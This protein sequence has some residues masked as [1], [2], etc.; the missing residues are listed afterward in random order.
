MNGSCT[1]AVVSNLR[2][3][4]GEFPEEDCAQHHLVVNFSQKSDTLIMLLQPVNL[5]I[6]PTHSKQS[7]F[8]NQ[9]E[10]DTVIF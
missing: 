5:P 3:S 8:Q 6:C 2:P 4:E 7:L 1:T 10:H 9:N